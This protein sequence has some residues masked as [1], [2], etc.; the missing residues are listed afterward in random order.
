[1]SRVVGSISRKIF[2]SDSDYCVLLFKVKENDVDPKYNGKT[3]TITGYFYDT[4]ELEDVA[5][6]GE[7]MKHAKYGEQFSVTS[8]Q[9]I[10][11]EDKSSV[12]AF[13]SG[14][15]F[16]GIGEAKATKIYEALGDNAIDLIKKDNSILYQVKCL[17]EKNIDMIISKLEELGQSTNTLLSLAELGFNPNDATLIYKK[18]KEKT[19]EIINDDI[20]TLFYDLEKITFNKV[21]RIAILNKIK[22]SDL[23]R[24]KAGIIY[25]ARTLAF[26]KGDTYSSKE[27]IFKILKIVIN[28]EP[29]YETYENCLEELCRDLKIILIDGNY[30]LIEYYDADNNIVKRL[31]YL[32]NKED[33]TYK[34]DLDKKISDFEFDNN[35]IYDDVQKEAIKKAFL[36][37]I[38]I[39]TGGPG[40]GKTTIIKSIVELYKEL[41]NR[42][43]IDLEDEIAL[44]APTGRA[45]KRIMEAT[46]CKASTIHRFLKWNKD[47]NKFQV[48]EYAKSNV[49]MVIIDEFSMVDTLLF[50]SLLKGL[51]YDTKIILVGD[52]NQLPS[53]SPGEV[54]K[55]LIESNVFEIIELKK[56]YRQMNDSNII[57][58]AYDVNMGE[59]DY[60]IFNKGEDLHF[61][62]SDSN[63]LKD[64]LTT[65]MKDFKNIDYHDFQIMA[66]M[67]KTLNGINNLNILMQDLFNPKSSNKNEIVIYDVLYR[68]GDK[69][70]QLMNMPDDN[71]Y[72]GDIGIILEI[73]NIK[74]EVTVDF[75][76]NI[77]TFNKSTFMN[78]TLGYVISIHKSQGSEFKT[79]IIPMLKEYGRMLYRKLIYTGITRS[80]QELILIGEDEA[81][82]RGVNNN[83]E[84]SRKTNLKDKIIN[85]Y[86][87]SK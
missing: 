37:N 23:R 38:L 15:M 69:V 59:I 22:K 18:Y 70:L 13:F 3:I 77:V 64:K 81:F 74:K 75:D 8:Y 67:Y 10:M 48:N 5:L 32:N 62:K 25:A 29:E 16:K 85:R 52:A 87:S 55:D 12:I 17:S 14:G 1:M 66:P 30:Q 65:L 58:L 79:V 2:K 21:D 42:K 43:Y 71:I 4:D 73:D 26:E 83:I 45:S 51:K 35:I 63:D 19:I 7:F 47:T 82:E 72:N 40:T 27:E 39:I 46:L 24:I 50:D 31:T 6:T 53:V 44:L 60:S 54:L 11:P 20:Y 68:V 33:M 78:F 57:N 49:K 34:V 56:L 61:Y 86:K 36:K 28:Y 84:N 80:K 41:Y 76:S 9:K